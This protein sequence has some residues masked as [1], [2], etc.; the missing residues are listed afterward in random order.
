[1]TGLYKISNNGQL[2]AFSNA[3]FKE[4]L[5]TEFCMLMGMLSEDFLFVTDSPHDMNWIMS[6]TWPELEKRWK[7][8]KKGTMVCTDDY[9]ERPNAIYLKADALSNKTFRD[10]YYS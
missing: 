4:Q 9:E 2:H 5:V 10:F 1:M 3:E 6:W 8:R 7:N